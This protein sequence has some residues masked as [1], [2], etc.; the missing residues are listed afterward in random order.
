VLINS[1]T[2]TS[3]NS[4]NTVDLNLECPGEFSEGDVITLRALDG[5]SG[6][7]NVSLYIDGDR[8]G[9]T[10]RHGNIVVQAPSSS[11]KVE[12]RYDG[13]F[14]EADKNEC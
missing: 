13:E 8:Y 12:F 1:N 5:E 11:F 10:N 4:P 2:E 3:N 14:M 7:E 9:A 6:L